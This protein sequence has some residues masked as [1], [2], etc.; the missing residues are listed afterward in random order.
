M[1]RSPRH[2]HRRWSRRRSHG[3]ES[4][5][6]R[7]PSPEDRLGGRFIQLTHRCPLRAC[8]PRRGNASCRGQG[9]R[10][11]R[12]AR[13]DGAPRPPAAGGWRLGRVPYLETITRRHP[14]NSEAALGAPCRSRAE[15]A[16][17]LIPPIGP[18]FPEPQ[19]RICVNH[20]VALL[21]GV[22]LLLSPAPWPSSQVSAATRTLQR[23]CILSA[24]T[25][26]PNRASAAKSDDLPLSRSQSRKAAVRSSGG[27]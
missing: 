20:A 6:P 25:E 12:R 10:S 27:R 19:D 21:H 14:G 3:H 22:G 13:R 4:A 15:R 11:G 7:P 9:G 26:P 5:E 18:R 23:V 16:P 17:G 8:R 1:A 24:S 2:G